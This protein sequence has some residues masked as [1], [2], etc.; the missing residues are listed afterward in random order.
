[1]RMP[2]N[3]AFNWPTNPPIFDPQRE[4]GLLLGRFQPAHEGHR[5]L[6]LEVI[7]RVGQVCIA[8]RQ[9]PIG[10]SNP[11]TFHE[12]TTRLEAMMADQQG[13][14][15]VI[16]VPNLTCVFHGRDTGWDVQKIELGAEME[17]ISATKIRQQMSDQG[18]I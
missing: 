2:K 7:R 8:V 13:R 3:L 6:A 9:M 16:S 15:I 1:M 14:F 4:T 12:I 17:S 11:F 5:A 18:M 10:P